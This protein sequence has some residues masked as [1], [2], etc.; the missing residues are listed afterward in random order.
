MLS[1]IKGLLSSKKFWLTVLGSA[2]VGGLQ[3]AGVGQEIIVMVASL[4]G[5]NIAGQGLADFGKNAK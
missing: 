3:M 1:A 4:F 5:L 2:V